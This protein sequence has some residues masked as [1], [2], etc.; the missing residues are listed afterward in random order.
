M[1]G[2]LVFLSF[3]WQN[4]LH[5]DFERLEAGEREEGLLCLQGP[6]VV[7]FLCIHLFSDTYSISVTVN[8]LLRLLY[9]EVNGREGPFSG[10]KFESFCHLIEVK[11]VVSIAVLLPL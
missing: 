4:V 7:R 1:Y 3:V 8:V 2:I 9:P 5:V 10:D 11:S 6:R